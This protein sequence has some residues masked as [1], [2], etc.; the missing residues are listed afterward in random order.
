M[1]LFI[2]LDLP[3][4]TKQSIAEFIRQNKSGYPDCGHWVEPANLHLTVNFLGEVSRTILP[5]LER[6]IASAGQS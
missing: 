1:R 3:A 6:A 2:A 4:E 5:E